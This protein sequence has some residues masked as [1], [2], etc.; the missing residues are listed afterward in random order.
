MTVCIGSVFECLC[1]CMIELVSPYF[2]N[3]VC[4]CVSVCVCVCVSLH[5]LG[6]KL[7]SICLNSGRVHIDCKQFLACCI[8]HFLSFINI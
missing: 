3:R 8:K 4:V 2:C 7:S 1:V 5:V 6:C